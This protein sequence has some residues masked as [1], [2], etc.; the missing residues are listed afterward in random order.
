MDCIFLL[1]FASITATI[2]D[3]FMVDQI[4]FNGQSIFTCL[5]CEAFNF[6]GNMESPNL[7]PQ[8]LQ[9]FHFRRAWLFLA[10]FIIQESIPEF[11]C[12]HSIR[13]EG[14]QQ[15]IILNGPI[16]RD[17]FYGGHLKSKESSVNYILIPHFIHRIN[18]ISNHG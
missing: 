15:D 6:I 13:I 4:Q 7:V 1:C 8:R 9:H 11:D 10:L 18:Q 5:L 2:H 12:I 17:V 3:Y 16:D 14:P